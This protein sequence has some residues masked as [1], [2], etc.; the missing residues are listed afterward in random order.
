MI[1]PSYTEI[2]DVVKLFIINIV[3][4]YDFML[5]NTLNNICCFNNK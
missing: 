5:D 1:F 4:Y 2:K 3:D